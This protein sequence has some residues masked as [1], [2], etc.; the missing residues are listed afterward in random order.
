M[1]RPHDV[2]A[3]LRLIERVR[4]A[5]PDVSLRTTFIVGYPGETD[6]EY[7]ALLDLMEAVA[8]DKV[9]V[10]AYS[11]E[12]GTRAATLP[13]RVPV[14][15]VADRVDQAMLLQQEIS[16]ARN[17][18][19]VGRELAVLIEGTGE[20]I[21]VGR[22]YRDAPEIDGMVLIPSELPIGEMIPCQIVAAQ[23]YDLVAHPL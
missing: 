13:D 12:A 17:E 5:M 21:S 9:G 18:Q 20:G 8:F 11:P 16:R 23:E 19:Q 6:Q 3:V 7:Q 22:T 10:F 4:E 15:V 1:G 2:D 14:S